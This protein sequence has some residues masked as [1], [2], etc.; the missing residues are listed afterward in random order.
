LLFT[1]QPKL[2]DY[3]RQAGYRHLCLSIQAVR[4]LPVGQREGRECHAHPPITA[5][6][7]RAGAAKRLPINLLIDF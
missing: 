5:Q 3:R 6:A 2:A 4:R 1:Q 7:A